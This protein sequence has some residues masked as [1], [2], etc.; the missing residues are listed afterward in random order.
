MLLQF[1]RIEKELGLCPAVRSNEEICQ[2]KF[3]ITTFMGIWYEY[4][5]TPELKES[6]S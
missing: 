4:L 3:N 5:I 2:A 1:I 6:I